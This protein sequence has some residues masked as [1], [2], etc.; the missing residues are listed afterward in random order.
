MQVKTLRRKLCDIKNRLTAV[1]DHVMQPYVDRI[2]TL[3]WTLKEVIARS[4]CSF[5]VTHFTEHFILSDLARV[6]K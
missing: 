4:L 1:R 2:R 3:Y 6:N 5:M